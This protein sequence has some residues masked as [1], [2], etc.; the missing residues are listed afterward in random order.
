MGFLIP[1]PPLTNFQLENYFQNEPSLMTF[2]EE[3]LYLKK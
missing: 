3:L 1:P 2:I